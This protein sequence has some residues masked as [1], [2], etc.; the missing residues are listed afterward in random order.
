MIRTMKITVSNQT[1][2]S[3]VLTSSHLKHGKWTDGENP[4][5]VVKPGEKAFINS[6]KKTGGA[7]GTEGYCMYIIVDNATHP[8]LEVSWSKP[9]SGGTS[10]VKADMQTSGTSYHP[11]V[12]ILLDTSDNFEALVTLKEDK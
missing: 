7:Y 3:L 8:T 10:F 5:P 6:Q 12:E 2:S 11:T 1:A 4:A 9:H